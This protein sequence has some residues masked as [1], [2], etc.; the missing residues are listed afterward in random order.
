VLSAVGGC[1][2]APDKGS[3]TAVLDASNDP[4]EPVNRKILDVN[5]FVDGLLLKPVAKAYVAVLPEDAR[6]AIRRVLD[7]MKEPT[8]FINNVLQGEFKRAGITLGRFGLNTTAGVGGI[9]DV[10]GQWGLDRQPAD[11]G[12]TLFVW[13]LP[14]GPYLILPILGPS[15]PRDAV[16]MGIDSYADPFTILAESK[17]LQQLTIGRFVAGGVDQRARVLDVLDQLEKNSLDFYAE[18]RSLSQQQRAAE[19]RHGA[20]PTPDQS[21]YND[22]GSAGSPPAERTAGPRPSV[23]P[24]AT[25]SPGADLDP[26]EGPLL[27]IPSAGSTRP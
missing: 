7:N 12:Q 13:G 23:T 1:T 5:Q 11:F 25:S 3:A 21:I 10:A 15:N 6:N 8:L 18:L 9:F 19:L 26:E 2:T 4:F 24:G 14:E 20:A 17:G 16:G 22:P 27:V